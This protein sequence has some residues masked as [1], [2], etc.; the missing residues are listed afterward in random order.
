MIKE[1]NQLS[2]DTK[3]VES[4]DVLEL[5]IKKFILTTFNKKEMKEVDFDWYFH[6]ILTEVFKELGLTTKQYK[7]IFFFNK[8]NGKQN[9]RVQIN[10]GT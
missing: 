7:Q 6:C 10:D 2:K 1:N 5:E 4:G 9:T 8:Q 3:F